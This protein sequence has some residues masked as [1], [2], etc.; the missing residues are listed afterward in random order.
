MLR[1]CAGDSAAIMF[2][3]NQQWALPAARQMCRELAR[4]NPLW[5]EEPTRPDDLM[6]H[7]ALSREI[8]PV[9]IATGEHIPNRVV[10]KNFI[11]GGAMHFIQADCTRLAGVSEFL[12]VSLLAKKAGLPI[13]RTLAT[14]GRFISIWFCLITSRWPMSR[15]FWST[16]PT[17]GR[18]LS[19]RP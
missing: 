14:W 11:S 5:I 18:T 16:F 2:D 1:E 19:F 6:A 15:C 9:K 3:A 13:V 4:L 17:C 7:I 10:F 12:T 8:A